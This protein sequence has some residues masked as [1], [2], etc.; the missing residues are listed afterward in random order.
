VHAQ[1]R[2]RHRGGVAGLRR[3]RPCH[4]KPRLLQ[5]R[6]VQRRPDLRPGPRVRSGR[7]GASALAQPHSRS[8]GAGRAPAPA[9]GVSCRAGLAQSTA[10]CRPTAAQRHARV[11]SITAES[12]GGRAARGSN[13]VAYLRPRSVSCGGRW[14]WS[15]GAR[16]TN[17]APRKR[18]CCSRCR[19][20]SGKSARILARGDTAQCG[21][22]WDMRDGACGASGAVRGMWAQDA[23][24][25]RSLR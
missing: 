24:G 22:A 19:H 25:R 7:A 18:Q 5:R 2:A 1:R 8:A 4:R 21:A 20:C 12:G 10:P 16:S 17:V 11:F 23:H 9:G 3:P 14:E 6:V 15:D 13:G